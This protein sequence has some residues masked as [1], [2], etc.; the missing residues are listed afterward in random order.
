MTLFY[1]PSDDS[2]SASQWWHPVITWTSPSGLAMTS[3]TALG[4][5]P[6]GNGDHTYGQ[7]YSVPIIAKGGTPITVTGYYTVGGWPSY[8]GGACAPF[9][10]DISIRIVAMP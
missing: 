7:A 2:G 3:D 8:G 4:L 1:F 6:C 9:P 5:G 10:I